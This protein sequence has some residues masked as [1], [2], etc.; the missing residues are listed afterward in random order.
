MAK[1]EWGVKRI[2]ANCNARYYD[3]RKD[4]PVCPS[5][6]TVFDP[7]ALLKSRRARP[8]PVEDMK[9]A[10]VVVE[11][12]ELELE[13]GDGIEGLEEAEAE[14]GV[15]GLEDDTEPGTDEEEDVLLE[16]ASELGEDDDMDEVVDVE[17]VDDER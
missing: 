8:T 2:C 10:P 3:M 12:D 13:V 6:G 17:V 5:C 16:D 14:A 11:D 15:E 9:K 1:P 4:P 7:E